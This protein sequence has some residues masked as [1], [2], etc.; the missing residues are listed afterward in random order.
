MPLYRSVHTAQQRAAGGNHCV[1][2]ETIVH[3]QAPRARSH[4][5]GRPAPDIC[6]AYDL[7]W[8]QAISKASSWPC[9]QIELQ[10]HVAPDAA[11]AG[12]RAATLSAFTI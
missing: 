8:D 4:S 2:T 11:R 10:K 3:I 1:I 5:Q 6:W 7:F 9:S 12:K